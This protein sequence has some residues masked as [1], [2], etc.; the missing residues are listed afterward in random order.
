MDHDG[1]WGMVVLAGGRSQRMGR[2]KAWLPVGEQPAVLRVVEVGRR[3]GVTVVVVGSPGRPLPPLPAGVERVDDP[4]GQAYEGPLSG[5]AV[6]LRH[7]H[8]RGIALACVA[9]CDCVFMEPDHVRFVL[10]ALQR[11]GADA[12]VPVSE[13]RSDGRAQ[14]HPLSGALRVSAAAVVAQSLFEDGR[15]AAWEL[16]EALGAER[17]A[18]AELPRPQV[19]RGHN[20]PQ[21]WAEAVARL[22]AA[23]DDVD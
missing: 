19:I 2:D 14:L 1:S 18:V 12:V 13:P 8:S 7:L 23:P 6:G 4:V 3:A 20:T 17:I 10:D 15:R 21:Q 16:S 5:L 22:R 9:P 11:S